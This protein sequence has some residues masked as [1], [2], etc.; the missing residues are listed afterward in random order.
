MSDEQTADTELDE[1][2]D[3][4]EG[5]EL[6]GSVSAVAER[7]REEQLRALAAIH[8]DIGD[9]LLPGVEPIAD[10]VL[11]TVGQWPHGWV[12]A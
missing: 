1:R 5:D 4:K 3:D 11:F 7:A 8:G 2:L 12:A 6:D 10:D 9:D